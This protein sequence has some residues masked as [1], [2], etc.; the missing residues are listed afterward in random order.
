MVSDEVPAHWAC[1]VEYLRIAIL[2]HD[3]RDSSGLAPVISAR[4]SDTFCGSVDSLLCERYCVSPPVREEKETS[5]P[6]LK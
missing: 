5:S 1:I 2:P 6:F 3:I 4:F